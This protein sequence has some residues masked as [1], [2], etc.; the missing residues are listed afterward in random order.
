MD[1]F[2]SQRRKL[3]LLG[4]ATAGLLVLPGM[5]E[6]SVSASRPRILTLSNMHTGETLKTEFFNGK[7]YNKSELVRLNHFFRDY[8]VNQIKPIDPHLF[9][10]LYR[11]QVML[12]T[13]K[14][15][16]LI[17]GYRSL[18]TNNR[19]R[20]SSSG[21]AKHSYHTLG[22]A[23][24]FHIEGVQLAN[25]RAAALKIRA[26]GVGYYPKSNFVHIDTGPVRHWS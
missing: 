16:Q 18:A 6:A 12:G 8:R 1:K 25:I 13:R 2:D 4:G 17:S 9:D 20:A 22:Q 21:V 3:L 5:A 26:G 10:Q 7:S 14:P 24:D 19:L 11:L 23:M 15:V